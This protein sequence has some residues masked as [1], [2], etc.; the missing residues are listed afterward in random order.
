MDPSRERVFRESLLPLIRFPVMELSTISNVVK[1]SGV[2]TG[3]ELSD[4]YGYIIGGD[5]LGLVKM[6]F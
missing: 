3:E 4:I 1:P 5:L 2:L 6:C